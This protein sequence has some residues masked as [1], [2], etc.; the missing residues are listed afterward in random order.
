MA[1]FDPVSVTREI[2]A[3]PFL[4]ARNFEAAHVLFTFDVRFGRRGVGARQAE[5]DGMPCCGACIV[6]TQLD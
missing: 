1:L 6:L 5:D 3:T 4:H 2:E